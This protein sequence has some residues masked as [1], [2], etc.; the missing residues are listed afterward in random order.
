M[1]VFVANV[2]VQVIERHLVA[3]LCNIFSSMTFYSMSD[4][5]VQGIVPE[6]E[7][8]KRRRIFLSHQIKKLEEGREIFRGVMDP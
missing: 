4:A 7:S 5:K 2:T 8:T 1:K 3:E 6:P